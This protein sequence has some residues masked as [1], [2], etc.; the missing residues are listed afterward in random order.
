M[1]YHILLLAVLLALIKSNAEADWVD[2]ADLPVPFLIRPFFSGYLHVTDDKAF[3]YAYHPSQNNPSKDPIIIWFGPGPGCSSLYSMM[4]S[5]G[6]FI[7]VQNTSE[8]RINKY[9]WNK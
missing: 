8:F 9:A 4:Y 1:K 3:F 2:P 7:F 5:K 6:P